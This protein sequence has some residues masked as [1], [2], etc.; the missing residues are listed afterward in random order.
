MDSL[1]RVAKSINFE[2][3]D[4]IPL[5][6]VHHFDDFTRKW[7]NH[8]KLD[9]ESKPENYYKYDISICAGDDSFFPSQKSVLEDNGDYTT[10]NDGWGRIIRTKKNGYFQQ[11]LDS[12]IKA[13]GNIDKLHFESADYEPRFT[14]MVE[15]L[16]TERSANRYIFTKVGGI[17]N[18][19]HRLLPEEDLLAN[20]A[21]EEE[22]CNE[23]FDKVTDHLTD[24]AYETLRRTGTWDAGLFVYDDM[25]NTQNC[26]FSPVL[27][28]KYFLPRYQSMISKLRT[29]GCR[30][31]Y[32]HSD[33][34]IAPLLD[35]LLETGFE[36]FNPLEPRSGL[37]LVELRE[38]Y[39]K[40]MVFFGGVCNTEILPRGNKDEIKAH[41]L[42]LLELGRE[43]GVVLGT[44]SISDDVSPEAYD[45]YMSFV[46]KYGNYSDG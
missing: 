31:F 4:R 33:G 35:L 41:I 11:T 9:A 27:F 13:P 5:W 42:P 20:M 16:I 40:R 10:S 17:Y 39:G 29:A 44:A 23:L 12:M 18:R 22:F 19:T 34:N 2:Q 43:G 25:A 28:E 38:K 26:M 3:P 7:I 24:M 30:H 37:K 15:Q 1:L 21:L 14:D 32:F 36:G 8:F 6:N 45:Y 46:K